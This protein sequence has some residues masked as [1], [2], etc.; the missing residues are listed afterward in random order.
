MKK[1]TTL[2]SLLV[3]FSFSMQSILACGPFTVDPLFSFTRHAEYPLEDFAKGKIGIIPSS[4]GRMSLFVFYR[5]LNELPLSAKEQAQYLTA[6]SNRIGT[7]IPDS[8]EERTESPVLKDEPVEGWIIIRAKVFVGDPK[9]EKEK[10]YPDNYFYYTNCLDD[11]FITATKTLDARIKSNGINDNVKEWL[12]GQDAVFANCGEGGK[13]PANVAE[14]AR[15]WLKKDRAYQIAAALLYSGKMPK[16]GLN[17]SKLLTIQT[18]LG[19]K[20]QNLSLPALIFV[21]QV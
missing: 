17:F 1:I 13:I 21:K 14:D 5:Q 8:A 7:H 6:L 3:L 10:R 9:L 12:N 19:T 15:D 16:P 11:A 4:Y 20:L 2:L 18:H